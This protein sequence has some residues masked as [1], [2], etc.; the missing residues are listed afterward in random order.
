ME[1]ILINANIGN[2]KKSEFFQ[3]MESLKKL[4]SNYCK[5]FDLKVSEDNTL[6]ISIQFNDKKELEK[7]FGNK[8]FNILKGSIRSLCDNVNIQVNEEQYNE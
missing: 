7:N 5:N 6:I 1:T 4:V 3:V 2:N 8:E